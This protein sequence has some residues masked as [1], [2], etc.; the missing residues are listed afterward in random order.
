M[1]RTI[2]ASRPVGPAGYGATAQGIMDEMARRNPGAFLGDR[3]AQEAMALQVLQGIGQQE[4]A[5]DVEHQGRAAQAI[6]SANQQET[7]R[8]LE[9]ERLEDM[10]AAADDWRPKVARVAGAVAPALAMGAM[11]YEQYNDPAAVALRAAKSARPDSSMPM[12]GE[13]NPEDLAAIQELPAANQVPME[14]DEGAI[15][16]DQAVSDYERNQRIMERGWG[17]RPSQQLDALEADRGRESRQE[18]RESD[19]IR[20]MLRA[21]SSPPENP[22]VGM[23]GY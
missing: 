3:R 22:Y 8:A 2:S 10:K 21:L 9:H 4:L 15:P 17:Q 6:L 7:R 13:M 18:L 1:A 19:A 11:A 16:I 5:R 20:K 23:E 14:F 12:P